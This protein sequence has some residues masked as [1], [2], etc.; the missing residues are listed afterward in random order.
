[1]HMQETQ[2]GV[3]FCLWAMQRFLYT[4]STL[5]SSTSEEDD[6]LDIGDENETGR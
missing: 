5:P 3:L 4:N 6:G 2:L 1:M